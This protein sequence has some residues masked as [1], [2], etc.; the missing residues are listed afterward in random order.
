MLATTSPTFNAGLVQLPIQR[1]EVLAA[2]LPVAPT[3]ALLLGTQPVMSNNV[4]AKVRDVPTYGMMSE[5]EIR[6]G[7]IRSFFTNLTSV[8]GNVTRANLTAAVSPTTDEILNDYAVFTTTY[9]DGGQTLP[10]NRTW[11][12][13]GQGWAPNST[14]ETELAQVMG[15]KYVTDVSSMLFATGANTLPADNAFGSLRAMISDGL[16]TAQRGG[17]GTDESA[18]ATYGGINRVTNTIARS[19]YILQTGSP[20]FGEVHASQGILRAF[21]NNAYTLVAPM[22]QGRYAAFEQAIYTQYGM[23]RLDTPEDLKIKGVQGFMYKNCYF[24]VE[25][26]IPATTTWQLFIDLGRPGMPNAIAKT[27]MQL[28]AV[29]R[30]PNAALNGA[31][32]LRWVFPHQSLVRNP[33]SCVLMEGLLAA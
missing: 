8:G 7:I 33:R 14:Y 18:Y 30:V 11:E 16:T 6:S 22:S 20:A 24:Y 5:A 26:A 2:Q 23:I 17:T 10:L 1:G 4:I 29:E 31:D 12:G 32:R 3:F 28:A 21:A 13:R 25:P 19:Q 9:G 15:Q 27:A